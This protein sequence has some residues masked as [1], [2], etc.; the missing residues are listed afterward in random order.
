MLINESSLFD[1]FFHQKHKQPTWSRDHQKQTGS[2]QSLSYIKFT[3]V[4]FQHITY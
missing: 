4:Y 2:P 1:V 3:S